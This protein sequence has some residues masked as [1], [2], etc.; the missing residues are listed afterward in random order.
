MFRDSNHRV[1]SA[2]S[3]GTARSPFIFCSY[4]FNLLFIKFGITVGFSAK[5]SPSLYHVGD[6]IGICPF[7]NMIR[8]DAGR[9]VTCMSPERHWPIAYHEIKSETMSQDSLTPKNTSPITA[10][11][12]RE[13]PKDTF[14]G[15]RCNGINHPQHFMHS[16]NF[17]NRLKKFLVGDRRV[18]ELRSRLDLHRLSSNDSG[19]WRT[20]FQERAAVSIIAVSL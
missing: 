17:V 3:I 7:D 5:K 14:E 12:E 6:I 10:R 2:L 13:G 16:S 11:S 1:S 20:R 18:N 19:V 8:I 9:S 15:A 4:L